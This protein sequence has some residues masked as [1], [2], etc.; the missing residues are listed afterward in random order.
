MLAMADRAA[1]GVWQQFA[2]TSGLRVESAYEGT[3]TSIVR[4]YRID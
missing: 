4:I 2:A 1:A 3:G